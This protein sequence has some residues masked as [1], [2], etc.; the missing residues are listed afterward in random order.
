[1]SASLATYL[2]GATT[3][4]SLCGDISTGSIGRAAGSRTETMSFSDCMALV[5][6]ISGE[7]GI[8]PV[9]ILR[10]ADVWTSRLDASDGAVTITCDRR[11][12]RLTLKRFPG[13]IDQQGQPGA[14]AMSKG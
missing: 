8:R 11:E 12:N 5:H 4:V 13:P 3:L 7:I 10:T 6:E 14:A 1:M 2:I 9:N